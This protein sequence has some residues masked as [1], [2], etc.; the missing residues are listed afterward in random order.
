M[1]CV[2][3]PALICVTSNSLPVTNPAHRDLTLKPEGKKRIVVLLGYA[4]TRVMG[5]IGQGGTRTDFAHQTNNTRALAE[6][7]FATFTTT[8]LKFHFSTKC[9]K[10]EVCI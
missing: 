5:R 10:F 3:Q 6:I 8:R 7:I 9:L 1:S 4:P 2:R